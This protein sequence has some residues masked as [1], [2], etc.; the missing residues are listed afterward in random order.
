M[1]TS[2]TEYIKRFSIGQLFQKRGDR[3]LIPIY[4]RNYEWGSGQ[5]IQL[6]DDIRDYYNYAIDED[7][8]YYIGTLI[9]NK[10][11]D[12]GKIIYETIDGQQRLTTFNV[13]IAVLSHL[14][15]KKLIDELEQVNFENANIDFE[16][17]PISKKT[18]DYV[19]R[20]GNKRPNFKN[21]NENIFEA[22]KI[23]EE[24]LEIIKD[25]FDKTFKTTGKTFEE[26]IHYLFKK[27][28]LLRVQVPENT[29]L[30]HY[31]EI[32][33]SRGEQLERHEILKAELMSKIEGEE[34]HVLRKT[35]NA[36]WEACSNMGTYV[37][38]SF[39]K[40]LRSKLFG[41]RWFQFM[42]KDHKE[43]FEILETEYAGHKK[44]SA[45]SFDEI[46]NANSDEIEELKKNL[47]E[48]NTKLEDDSEYRQ[49]QEVI[50]FE[51]FL[52]HVLKLTVDELQI[53]ER[54]SLDDKKLIGFFK[55]ALKK[56]DDE[57]NFSKVFIYNLLKSKFL[58]DQYVLKRKY[59][60]QKD[61]WSLNVIKYYKKGENERKQDS[62]SYINTFENSDKNH[63][64][65]LLLS[66]FHVSIPTLSY[67][68]W[69]YEVLKY[70]SEH[71]DFSMN[72]SQ[73]EYPKNINAEGYIERLRVT[74]IKFLKYRALNAYENLSYEDMLDENI[75]RNA[76]ASM[77]SK[78]LTFGNIKT[79]LVFNF[80]DYLLWKQR[81]LEDGL[82]NDFEFSFRSSVE[83][84]Y[85]Q[86]PN[87]VNRIEDLKV[88]NSIGNLCL[89]SHSNNSKLSNLSPSEKRK[90]YNN[91][92]SKDSIKQMVMMKE[93]DNWDEDK[94]KKHTQNIHHLLQ[95]V[96]FE[97]YPVNQVSDLK[98]EL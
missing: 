95:R 25:D 72:E 47:K 90:H 66:M 42:C 81:I 45:L 57:V 91:S 61:E 58:L 18:V 89:I 83:H 82:V 34:H 20:N 4:Q 80:I 38:M 44:V 56:T 6:L 51:N 33:N 96:V 78:R 5:I 19:F 39:P 17:R 84:Y 46:I 77:D 53:D 75:W 55:T 50:N 32:M 7:K 3:F 37:Q 63:E 14:L 35:Y 22:V 41:D 9:V 59:V 70:L 16:S 93:R 97:D 15:D 62:Y 13:I 76:S 86:N 28:V 49:F 48:E 1:Q 52:L 10:R 88:L 8:N 40:E 2:N 43:L 79:N 65:I 54:I 69:L 29:D 74:A 30:N 87:S 67:K 21:F 36:V 11:D 73:L 26:F 92:K 68:N 31:F 12:S 85:P 60:S 24:H 23:V 64:L 98:L 94:I 71:Y 27:V